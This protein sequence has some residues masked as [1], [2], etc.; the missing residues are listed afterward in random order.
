MLNP[1]D[2]AFKKAKKLIDVKQEQ[3]KTPLK[4]GWFK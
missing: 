1:I 3:K 4:K 2:L